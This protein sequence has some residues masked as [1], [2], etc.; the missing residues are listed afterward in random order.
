M[1][2]AHEYIHRRQI[3]DLMY[4]Q[5]FLTQMFAVHIK[6]FNSLYVKRI[7]CQEMYFN[8]ETPQTN[9]DF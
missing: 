4:Q 2:E 1:F 9:Y 7:K 3:N 6:I 5:I 8:K